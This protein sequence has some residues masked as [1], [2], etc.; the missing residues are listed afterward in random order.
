MVTKKSG[1]AREAKLAAALKENLKRR[2]VKARPAAA[3]EP[4]ARALGTAPRAGLENQPQNPPPSRPKG[5]P[6]TI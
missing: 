4:P 2:K 5:A 1:G 6:K 3:P